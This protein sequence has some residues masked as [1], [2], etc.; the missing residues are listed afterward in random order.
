MRLVADIE[1]D[2]LYHEVTQIHCIVA[3]DKDTKKVHTFFDKPLDGITPTGSI[4]DGVAFLSQAAH[5]TGHN[6]I[7][8]DARVIRK[9]YP[10][11]VIDV[12]KITDTMLRS[13]MFRPHMHSHPNCPA[14]KV[15]PTGRKPIGPHSLEN[16]G[17]FVGLGKVENEDWSTFT[18]HMLTRCIE[19]VRITDRVD[20]LLAQEQ[21]GWDWG[22][23]EWIEKSF[24]FIMSEQEGHGWV[25]DVQGAGCALERLNQRIIEIDA[26]VLPRI[27]PVVVPSD[28]PTTQIRKK[29]GGYHPNFIKW[30][31]SCGI[32]PSFIM[33]DFVGDFSRVSFEQ[34]NLASQDQIKAY[35]L[36][37]GWQP[38]EWNYKKDATG[39]RNLKDET[40]KLI[41]TSPK[42]TEDSFES[43]SDDSG[44]LIAERVTLCHRRSQIEGWLSNVRPDG[45]I[46][47]SGNTC[48][49][50]TGRV[51]HRVVVNVPKAEENVFFGKEMR[52][53][54]TVPK[55]YK[56]VG[57]DLAAL[58]DRLA[59]HHTYK[60][61]NGDYA[62]TL[63][64][65]DPHQKT[66]DLFGCTRHKGKTCN[67][68]L[69]YGAQPP[70]VAEILGCEIPKA[71]Y[72]W[73]LWWESHPSLKDL[74]EAI[75]KG[76]TNR[77]FLKNGKLSDNAWIKG[78]DGRKIYIRSTHSALNARIQNAGSV[79]N[80][81]TT[82]YIQEGIDELWLDAHLVGNF[83]DETQAE[84][85][86]ADVEAYRGVVER[87]VTRVN[88]VFDFA[89]PM[90]AE[91]KVG[92]NW[93]ETH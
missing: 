50:N 89:I 65:G 54:F 81:L 43:L 74:K 22:F 15:T 38:T 47:A 36:S 24:R 88:E 3:M 10:E 39:K 58:E 19:D 5:V 59:G 23:A 56:L 90:A 72:F 7:D 16:W 92:N 91:T 42:L 1:T 32:G 60:F 27:P 67:H 2:G 79:V 20:T 64:K 12:K 18:P 78:I 57:G 35:L 83:H 51:T 30:F 41:V 14:S 70:K 40:G 71:N 77:G 52:S 73:N 33:A 86:E 55:G 75:E 82:I 87:A 84:V 80:K 63:L 6:W 45:R 53:L 69:K 68:A 76:L 44:K 13:Y 85:A 26:L 11:F 37:V 21:E 31:E 28:K 61:D 93:K 9:F 49:T 66:A 48:G 46:G 29:T 4:N 34:I 25:F 17:Y 8:Y 62:D